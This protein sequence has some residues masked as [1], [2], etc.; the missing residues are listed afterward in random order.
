MLE[1]G[2]TPLPVQVYLF[3]GESGQ[4]LSSLVTT[5]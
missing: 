4:S 5:Y 3:I 1:F 2:N